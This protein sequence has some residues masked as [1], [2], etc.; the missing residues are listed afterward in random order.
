MPH[1]RWLAFYSV[2]GAHTDIGLDSGPILLHHRHKFRCIFFSFISFCD[3]ILIMISGI[4]WW[5]PIYVENISWN[6]Q[7]FHTSKLHSCLKT[8]FVL[9]AVHCCHPT[10]ISLSTGYIVTIDLW[11]GYFCMLSANIQA[12]EMITNFDL[13]LL[14]SDNFL[15]VHLCR[16]F[17]ILIKC[18][19]RFW[20]SGSA[21][22][23]WQH[24]Q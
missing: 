2:I 12:S 24:G 8:T 18:C 19:P 22:S 1:S 5:S 11:W 10:T 3:I 14:Q 17:K 16:Q 9:C 13:N 7:C 6:L 4:L 20:V 21:Q 15:K 23:C